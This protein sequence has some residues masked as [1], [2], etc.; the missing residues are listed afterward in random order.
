M[1]NKIKFKEVKS[2]RVEL[3]TT[4]KKSISVLDDEVEGGVVYSTVEV[5]LKN[6]LISIN[7]RIA[8][9]DAVGIGCT[10]RGNNGFLYRGV[11]PF[12]LDGRFS[13][14][15]GSV[16]SIPETFLLIGGPFKEGSDAPN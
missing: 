6:P 13:I 16:Y 9:L 12:L 4:T 7:V 11:S 14:S 15:E 2:L 3:Q 10:Y 5:R 8:T 1:D